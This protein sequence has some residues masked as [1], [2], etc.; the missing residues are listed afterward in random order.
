MTLIKA[1]KFKMLWYSL[2]IIWIDGFFLI[3]FAGKYFYSIFRKINERNK[4]YLH[5]VQEIYLQIFGGEYSFTKKLLVKRW[6][7]HY[8]SWLDD[9]IVLMPVE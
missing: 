9:Q 2:S 5:L 8:H 4:L 1:K 6:C 7:C 3:D